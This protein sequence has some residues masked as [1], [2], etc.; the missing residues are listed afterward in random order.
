VSLVGH[1]SL[2][3][4]LEQSLP[5]SSLLLGPEST[6][7]RVLA[8]HLA[9]DHG[10][11][12]ADYYAAELTKLTATVVASLCLLVP[13]GDVRAFVLDLDNS[14][15]A[16]QHALLK[17]LE[18]PP[19]DAR[20]LL[21]AS[22]WPL[23]TIMSRC[24][25]FKVGLLSEPGVAKVLCQLGVEEKLAA[26]CAPLGR[27]QVAPA[28]AAATD[29]REGSRVRSHVSAAIKSAMNGGSAT[30]SSAV[31]GWGEEHTQLLRQWA[32]ELATGRWLFFDPSYA[33]GATSAQ[34]R[35]VLEW[36]SAYD[37]TSL[38]GV[39]ALRRAF[40]AYS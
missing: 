38:V 31:R 21:V 25:V 14:S 20:F 3:R 22:R 29:A 28:Y 9:Y 24:Q 13:Y 27:G 39:V 5:Q 12:P 8:E 10:C 6:G 36:L 17:V 33:P 1:S 7:K 4:R 26:R 30:Y 16:A 23:P 34:G 18:E 35:K 40:P 32:H 2:R 37:G 11:Q 15:D 19:V